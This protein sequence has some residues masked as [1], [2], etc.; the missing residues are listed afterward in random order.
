M[1]AQITSD[2]SL[3]NKEFDKK[4]DSKL[5]IASISDQLIQSKKKHL[6]E[7]FDL[8]LKLHERYT[9]L[10]PEGLTESQEEELVLADIDYIGRIEL[11]VYEAKDRITQYD[12][13]V[14]AI[15]KI[16]SLSDAL[17]QT[18][19]AFSQSKERFSIIANKIKKECCDIVEKA[20]GTPLKENLLATMPLET[21]LRDVKESH[22][23]LQKFAIKLAES[24]R[25]I[26]TKE[27]EI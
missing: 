21:M 10:R 3:L 22:S 25:A 20:E 19:S 5:D 18:K 8:I 12:D 14:K 4:I 15:S 23:E 2:L 16:K 11:K 9:E 7:H 13:E 6:N 24:L 17:G 27:D 1:A 26:N